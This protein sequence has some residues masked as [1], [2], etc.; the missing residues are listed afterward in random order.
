MLSVQELTTLIA[1]GIVA[2]VLVTFAL[3]VLGTVRK[4]ASEVRL[5]REALQ[6]SV[7]EV[8][9]TQRAEAQP[10]FT[11]QTTEL[12]TPPS[13]ERETGQVP[14]DSAR[15]PV[16]E[17][18][19][20]TGPQKAVQQ[21][22]IR[23]AEEPPGFNSLDEI[24]RHYGLQG[25]VLF[26]SAGQVIDY[27]GSVEAEKVAALLAEAYSV[28]SMS[29]EGVKLIVLEDD[30]SEAVAKLETLAERDVYVYVRSSGKAP[31]DELRR[32]VASCSSF[33][34]SLLG[35]RRV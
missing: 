34:R 16:T 18:P 32:A 12:V 26:D 5:M 9:Q 6:I 7:R 8:P 24:A 3:L 35:V 10:E 11:P 31:H 13:A 22:Q 2:A 1:V 33:L 23:I 29:N 28:I 4:L 17:E 25:L 30:V 27:A 15:L 20:I 19:I 21:P 14:T